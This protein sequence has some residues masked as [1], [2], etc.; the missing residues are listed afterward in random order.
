MVRGFQIPWQLGDV[1]DALM[2]RART[3]DLWRRKSF[4]SCGLGGL[5]ELCLSRDGCLAQAWE[6]DDADGVGMVIHD[7]LTVHLG[8]DLGREPFAGVDAQTIAEDAGAV[9]RVF[10]GDRERLVG[11]RVGLFDARHA[12]SLLE[13]LIAE[14]PAGGNG[15]GQAHLRAGGR[16]GHALTH[17][18]E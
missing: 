3:R 17:E 4:V 5:A 18:L 10:V 11:E 9:V 12:P 2:I 8:S 15:D 14:D 6:D 13:F 1:L 16:F 7:P